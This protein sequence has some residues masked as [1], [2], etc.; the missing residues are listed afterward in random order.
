MTSTAPES[1][2]NKRRIVRPP[3]RIVHDPSRGF[4]WP[5]RPWRAG[6]GPCGGRR[7]PATV[8]LM[9]TV[10]AV[11]VLSLGVVA[12]P[13]LAQAPAED[14]GTRWRILS[15]LRA[16]MAP[17][18]PY[19]Q[20]DADGAEPADGASTAPWMVRPLGR[21]TPFI[22]VIANPLNPEQ[23]ARAAR[24]MV[25]IGAAIAVAQRRS[26]AQYRSRRGRRAA[27]GAL[28]GRGRGGLGGRGR[29]R[30]AHRRRV[31]RGGGRVV[32]PGRVH[33]GGGL[34][35]RSEGGRGGGAGRQRRGDGR[36]GR[37]SARAWRAPP[38][39][40]IARPRP[41]CSSAWKRPRCTSGRM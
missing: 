38:K 37:V 7:A 13:A 2:S 35:Q 22:E 33:V 23:Q 28:A 16:A 39:S 18:L 6:R 17:A 27:H 10:A 31:A 8:A 34:R 9:R 11:A 32:Q 1:A 24:A 14:A 5:R 25:Q 29:G 41:T 15:E 3:G 12:A 21:D 4:T 19:P 30:R 36:G 40:D 20:S 26:E